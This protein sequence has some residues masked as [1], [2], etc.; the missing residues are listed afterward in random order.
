EVSG[1]PMTGMSRVKDINLTNTV[2]KDLDGRLLYVPNSFM[3]TNKVINYS[4]A[5]FVAIRIPVWLS[6]LH[7][8]DRIKLIVLD[9]ANM[10]SCILPNVGDEEQ[11][12]ISKLFEHHNVRRY[13]EKKIDMSIFDPEIIIKDIQKEKVMVEIKIWI[14]DV[15]RRDQIV[16]NFMDDLR[17]RFELENIEFGNV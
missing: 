8:F 13:L 3:V 10:E 12:K 7:E 4:R 16:T 9:V 14:R 17:K 15:A 6:S 11:K 1:L 2:L 5:G